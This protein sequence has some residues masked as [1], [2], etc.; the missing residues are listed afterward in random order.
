MS[1]IQL[2]SNEVFSVR[3]TQDENGQ[4]WFVGKDILHALEYAESSTP[5]QIMQS[6]PDIWKGIKRIDSSSENG[7]VQERE[8]LCL[9]EQGVYFF[10]G[11]SDK[12]KALPYQMWIAGDVVP[13]IMHTGSYRVH[14]S[15][16]E[17]QRR[18]RE[19]DSKNREIDLERA[20]ILQRMIDAPAVP[21]S[22]ESKAVIQH[23]IFSIISGHECVSMLPQVHERYYSATELGEMFGVSNKQIGKIAKAHGLKPD[24]GEPSEYGIWVLT[25][26]RY[27]CHQ[28]STFKYN[29]KAVHWFT[30]HQELLRKEV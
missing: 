22:E 5:A 24:E 16:D 15:D 8:M 30:E 6:V 11:R 25:K 3:T 26:S 23:E 1:S 14:T 17:L 10:L 9:S 21:L 28:C 2:Y 27:S 12:P 18:D 19:L 20:K 29:D 13:S 7:V 4:V